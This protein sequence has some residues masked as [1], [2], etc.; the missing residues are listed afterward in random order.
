RI[1]AVAMVPPTTIK[2]DG[3][4]TNIPADPPDRMAERRSMVPANRPKIVAI[5]ISCYSLKTLGHLE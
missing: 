2:T 3:T 4:L 5:S 1:K